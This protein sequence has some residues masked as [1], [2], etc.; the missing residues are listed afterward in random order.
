MQSNIQPN[1]NFK[2][3]VPTIFP[4][5]TPSSQGSS[6]AVKRELRRGRIIAKQLQSKKMAKI[7]KKARIDAAADDL[8]NSFRGTGES[9]EED[10][11]E[12]KVCDYDVEMRSF[13]NDVCSVP[14]RNL[15]SQF[16]SPQQRNIHSRGVT[17]FRL[18]RLGC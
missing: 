13:W 15:L 4:P 7:A 16:E 18:L 12:C 9:D 17:S 14:N 6:V 2:A 5:A 10:A 3:Y 8:I 1:S 11:V